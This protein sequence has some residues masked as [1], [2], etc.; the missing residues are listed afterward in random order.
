MTRSAA[1][2]GEGEEEVGDDGLLVRREGA[3]VED[4][5]RHGA[6]EHRAGVRVERHGRAKLIITSRGRR[7]TPQ[8]A[9]DDLGFCMAAQNAIAM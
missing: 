7:R 5:D 4:G 3:V 9:P 2:R 8:P 1:A 6:L